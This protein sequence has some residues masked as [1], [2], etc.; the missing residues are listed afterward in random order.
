MNT[1]LIL[2]QYNLVSD[3]I[4]RKRVKEALDMLKVMI[5]KTELQQYE[6]ERDDISTTY[7]NILKYAISG[8]DD[9]Q[10]EEVYYKTL[11]ATIELAD[12][13]KQSL[14]LENSPAYRFRKEQLQK[15]LSSPDSGT[16]DALERISAGLTVDDILD[17][18]EKQPGQRTAHQKAL[19]HIFD[20]LWLTDIYSE[21]E[22]ELAQNIFQNNDIQWF[23]RSVFVTSIT[24][25][26]LRTFDVQKFNILFHIFKAQEDQISQR[27]IAGILL[28]LFRH[29]KRLFLYPQITEQLATAYEQ[30][31]FEKQAEHT[32][33]QLLKAKDTDRVT[34]KLQEEIMPELLKLQPKIQEKLNLDKILGEE[35]FNDQNPDWQEFFEETPGLMDKLQELTNMQ[36]EGN[37]VFMSTFSRLKHFPFFNRV[38]NWFLPFYK[39]NPTAEEALSQE[40][41]FPD[42]DSLIESIAGS[43][44]MCNSDKY[45]FCLNLKNMPAQ[46]KQ[47][48]GNM[49]QSEFEQMKEVAEDEELV[50]QES[51]NNTIIVQYIQ[52]LYRFF[53]L[54]PMHPELD[55]I[56][57]Y[58]MDFFNKDFYPLIVKSNSITRKIGEYY[59]SR[60]HFDKAAEV[61]E[62]LLEDDIEDHQEVFEKLAYSFEKQEA[63][64]QAI[65]YY[66]KAE[67]FETNRLWNLKKIAFCYR[68]KKEPARA[69]E[70]YKQAEKLAPED[71]YIKVHLGHTHLDREQYSNALEYYYQAEHLSPDNYHIWRPLA[72]CSFVL[73]DFERAQYYLSGLMKKEATKYDFMNAGHI[74]L[75]QKDMKKA[76]RLYLKSIEARKNDFKAFLEAFKDDKKHLLKHGVP[77]GKIALTLDY[78]RY[79]N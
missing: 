53:K 60:K 72:W 47:M 55:D 8:V 16:S 38:Q 78:I 62:K 50:N 31:P 67:L 33:I 42:P 77:E 2:K 18:E 41:A 76:S 25:S 79:N 74:A 66:K 34:R 12:K 27:A 57:S 39:S 5:R 24:L 21:K 58:R 65:D 59:F 40:D 28:A 10:Q 63:Y 30:N 71:I 37:D 73:G 35:A 14:L 11:R 44:H 70:F 9:P 49:M 69:V 75:C 36:M 32:I 13:V 7:G 23:E 1:N 64:E 29:N 52:D 48:M 4:F 22:N 17:Q 51:K 15:D 54:H 68:M 3:L 6:M 56:F 61:F 46:Q 19:D 20:V 26:L 43:H 45:S